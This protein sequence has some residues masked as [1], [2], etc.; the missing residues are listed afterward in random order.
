MEIWAANRAATVKERFPLN[1]RQLPKPS[2]DREGA[3]FAQPRHLRPLAE[4]KP[5]F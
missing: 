5:E 1:S 3:V 4:S 2:R